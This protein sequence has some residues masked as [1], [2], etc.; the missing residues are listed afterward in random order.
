MIIVD[1][2]FAGSELRGLSAAGRSLPPFVCYRACPCGWHHHMPGEGGY[3]YAGLCA[4][5]GHDGSDPHDPWPT[6]EPENLFDRRL[7]VAARRGP[8]A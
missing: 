1:G 6:C 2:P 8:R 5:F 3:R 7:G 4:D